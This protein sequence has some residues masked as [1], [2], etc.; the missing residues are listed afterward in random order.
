M[1]NMDA[2]TELCR[3]TKNSEEALKIAIFH[4]RGDKYAKTYKGTVPKSTG[5]CYTRLNL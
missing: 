1:R 4:K 3:E 2:H 5:G